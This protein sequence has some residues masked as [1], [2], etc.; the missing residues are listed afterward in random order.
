MLRKN[1]DSNFP[2]SPPHLRLG[3]LKKKKKKKKEGAIKTQECGGEALQN[4]AQIS[5]W[6]LEEALQKLS[7]D[8]QGVGTKM[9][10]LGVSKGVREMKST[11]NAINCFTRLKFRGRGSRS[12]ASSSFYPLHPP[13]LPLKP[14]NVRNEQGPLVQSRC[15]V[16]RVPATASPKK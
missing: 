11:D 7:S 5:L 12:E 9:P 1:T 10:I 16:F 15:V 3:K 14:P 4:R 2:T 6:N 8:L 13:G